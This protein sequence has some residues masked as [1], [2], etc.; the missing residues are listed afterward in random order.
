MLIDAFLTE[1]QA[2]MEAV[3]K[4]LPRLES[5]PADGE[6]WNKITAFFEKVRFSAPFADFP[7][8]YKLADAALTESKTRSVDALPAV[9]KKFARLKK[10]MASAAKLR[11]EPRESDA[12]LVKE[13]DAAP[14]N[15]HP[16]NQAATVLLQTAQLLSQKEKNVL[17][18]ERDLDSREE[19]L[20]LRAK[21]LDDR[22]DDLNKR[23]NGVFKDEKKN[24]DAQ[25]KIAAVLADIQ[26]REAELDEKLSFLKTQEKGIQD[27]RRF[28]AEKTNGVR[29]L[30][31]AVRALQ[32][33]KE[34]KDK[35]IADAERKL[36]DLQDKLNQ[37]AAESEQMRAQINDKDLRQE[38]NRKLL[39]TKNKKIQ[40]LTGQ[41]C[42]LEEELFEK[43]EAE[44]RTESELRQELQQTKQQLRD[45]E[46]SLQSLQLQYARSEE[47]VC[48]IGAD[49]SELQHKY[50]EMA[51]HFTQSEQSA[52]DVLNAKKEAERQ[53]TD[54]QGRFDILRDEMGAKSEQLEQTAKEL[55]ADRR[56]AEKLRA[57]LRAAG[58]PVDVE[59]I[60]ENFAALLEGDKARS[61]AE[62]Y[63]FIR[64]ARSKP[65]S[66]LFVSLRNFVA[67]RAGKL[68]RV[69]TFDVSADDA[70]VDCGAWD[71]LDRIFRVLTDNS[72][73]Y[74]APETQTVFVRA[75]VEQSGAFLKVNY[76]DN[77]S[78]VPFEKIRGAA[79]EAGVCSPQD[80]ADLSKDRL[81]RCL[82][83]PR[84]LR[85]RQ[86]RGL[87]DAVRLL[88]QS[89]GQIRIW[90][91]GGV[92][93]EFYLPKQY[94]FDKVLTF[95]AGGGKYAVP[96]NMVA[97]TFALNGTDV[98]NGFDFKGQ[99]LPV[100]SLP[101]TEDGS[102][103]F[104]MVLQA[105]IFNFLMPVQKITETDAFVSFMPNANDE[106][107]P[108]LKPCV[109]LSGLRADWVDV[110]FLL[111]LRPPEMT[112][113]ALP[114]S[115][116]KPEIPSAAPM[117]T[118]L[119]YRCD[120]KN[121]GAVLVDRVLKIEAF[122]GVKMD[123]A[124][125]SPVFIADG[126]MLPL[127][128]SASKKHFPFAQTV[129]IFADYALAIQDVLDIVDAPVEKAD[130]ILY[131][132][133][134]IPVL[135]D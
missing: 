19:D 131:Q 81:L 113:A 97:E 112:G 70:D 2:D 47:N 17:L 105:G 10:I 107:T 110:S 79:V 29:E 116:E 76:R 96:L 11:R 98:K 121:I 65:L 37:T 86:S 102:A 111:N 43:S 28:L 57:E 127:K 69:Y 126:K 101:G 88:E 114:V 22:E 72:L 108:Y 30:K 74:A 60:Q 51:E 61:A 134:K 94:L 9:L 33:E 123:G 24:V 71:A 132:G 87:L 48:R 125:N 117:S 46:N 103:A 42:R 135:K 90:D 44:N 12:D 25:T 38:E 54:L 62:L 50:D 13:D 4:K 31:Q 78:A 3:E 89:G 67:V 119:I 122:D 53:L 52:G 118:Y 35:K 133:K 73:R 6:T 84:V 5:N 63:A 59:K 34:D 15:M 7:R 129:L 77:S 26:K 130:K 1:V 68:N 49:L 45:S 58:W 80:A 39:E 92:C 56:A 104:G 8:A 23:E 83:H 14:L 124:T 40:D 106:K 99:T 75:S 16:T 18:Q 109:T 20:L 27:A 128:D 55:E 41:I 82:F 120:P 115:V 66:E 85:D 21:K 95:E 64:K 36:A 91:D 100:L 32:T 93:V